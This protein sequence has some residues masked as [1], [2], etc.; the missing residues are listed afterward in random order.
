MQGEPIAGGGTNFAADAETGFF[1][2]TEGSSATKHCTGFNG[3]NG[4]QEEVRSKKEVRQRA[5]NRDLTDVTEVRKKESG[6][7]KKQVPAE[8]SSNS[9]PFGRR[10]LCRRL[11]CRK[12]EMLNSHQIL[13]SRTTQQNNYEPPRT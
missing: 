2:K 11:L 1:I 8:K 4:G 10:L 7:R 5:V 3:C 13:R 9:L 6:I 12:L